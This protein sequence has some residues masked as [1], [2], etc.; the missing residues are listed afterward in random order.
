MHNH[1][2]DSEICSNRQ[3]LNNS[4]KNKA[5]DDLCARPRKLIYKELRSQCL[6]TLTYKDIRDISWK[7]HTARSSQLLPL[8][9]DIEETHE[10]I[11]AVQVLTCST[12]LAC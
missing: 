9:T 6:R 7:T 4:D 12:V 5:M 8:Q 10:A 1:D 11:I 2:A 3:I